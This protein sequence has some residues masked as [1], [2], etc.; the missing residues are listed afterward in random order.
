[1]TDREEMIKYAEGICIPQLQKT[2]CQMENGE[3]STK[4][5]HV[6]YE[7][8]L[9]E[10]L[11]RPFWG[12][13]PLLN[14]KTYYLNSKD[15][16]IELCEW[17]RRVLRDGTGKDSDKRFDKNAQS[18]GISFFANQSVTELAG[19]LIGIYF[20]RGAVF[21]PMPDEQKEQL[22]HYTLYWAETALK[23]SWPN[24]HYWFPMF[25]ILIMDKLGYRHP[26]YDQL[27]EFGFSQ[28]EGLYLSKGWYSD[29]AFG[30]FDYYEAWAHNVYPLLWCLID[31]G[32]DKKE[33]YK[34]RTEEFLKEY[35]F[36]FDEQ[37]A[38]PPFGRSLSFRFAA[39]APFALA[40]LAGC[41]MDYAAAR[42]IT[43]KNMRYFR[44]N[45]SLNADG[46]L[47]AG[48]FYDS[49]S[50][51]ES[52][53]SDGAQYW[54]T[55]GFIALLMPESHPFWR[56]P[57]TQ[58]NKAHQKAGITEPH[59]FDMQPD[60]HGL[61][62]RTNNSIL[63]SAG[64]AGGAGLFRPFV[65]N[66]GPDDV[67]M[68]FV[69]SPG[70]GMTLYN[71][72]ANYY[73]GRHSHHFNDMAAYYSK[74]CYNSLTGFGISSRDNVS[75]D[76]AAGL[77]TPDDAMTSHRLGFCDKGLKNGGL[78]STHTPFS[79]DPGT[80]IKTVVVPLGGGCHLRVHLL[81][82]SQPYKFTD[83]GFSIGYNSDRCSYSDG[84]FKAEGL[85]SAVL[86]AYAAKIEHT[87]KDC[88]NK[89]GGSEAAK[90]G[91]LSGMQTDAH[92]N[93][94]CTPAKVQADFKGKSSDNTDCGSLACNNAGNHGAS[95]AECADPGSVLPGN[96]WSG[97]Q[98]AGGNGFTAEGGGFTS[99]SDSFTAGDDGYTV[100][101]DDF[102]AECNGFTAEDG[103]FTSSGGGFESGSDS[104]T[105]S[106]A[107]L[108]TPG[109]QEARACTD[110]RPASVQVIETRTE[111]FNIQPGFHLYAPLASYPAV[112][113][114]L[115]E[116]GRYI[117][118]NLFYIGRLPDEKGE[119]D[120][121]KSPNTTAERGM[122]DLISGSNGKN[123]GKN[124]AGNGAEHHIGT[125]RGITEN[126]GAQPG[127][128]EDIE[129]SAGTKSIGLEYPTAFENN[130]Q[131]GDDS[132]QDMDLL[133]P[134]ARAELIKLYDSELSPSM[135][136]EK[137]A[138]KVE[139]CGETVRFC[140][141]AVD[142]NKD[143]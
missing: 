124:A 45:I 141:F 89:C 120:T 56:Q 86:S 53:M 57:V 19:L 76:C 137:I 32:C 133:P 70:H 83:G 52:Y 122:L 71:N 98:T 46:T 14:E 3:V 51:I 65:L 47:A 35:V 13:A 44:K 114:G 69:R 41:E 74:F 100:S 33:I 128:T 60:K 130:G 112:T 111:R 123:G 12:I 16:R 48:Y 40:A 10:N 99:G 96:A 34:K 84:V 117:L 28:L 36:W 107:A 25:C 104:F 64:S 131:N 97:S 110:S 68:L 129:T 61:S 103:S 67:H 63:S 109:Q 26:N 90:Q 20:A 125:S 66:A 101:G 115:L 79:N 8:N 105:S 93:F 78:L 49:N 18:L 87:D 138:E 1:M 81:T 38:F 118:A 94:C 140:D 54:F 42:E 37:G 136:L 9:L 50:I 126:D 2:L 143:F 127:C 5:D 88:S 95:V 108:K 31:E 30:R 82:L 85:C 62:N 116:A 91:F 106:G 27:I 72:T 11:C 132:H 17:L 29:G 4:V 39:V 7:S 15:G 119:R 142:F 113:T 80:T 135:I 92:A 73:Q 121:Q 24:N 22:A 55:K 134:L 59:S 102:T 43:M 21:D 6:G 77:T 23:D 75:L 58:E 139:I